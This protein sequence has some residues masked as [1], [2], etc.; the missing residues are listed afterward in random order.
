M[1]VLERN[2]V[3]K[4]N[5]RHRTS[6]QHLQETPRRWAGKSLET[7][8]ELKGMHYYRPSG[9]LEDRL[10]TRDTRNFNCLRRVESRVY[11]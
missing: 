10:E 8:K 2:K 3:E 9:R 4:Q 6:Q 1:V 5:S 11:L 7:P